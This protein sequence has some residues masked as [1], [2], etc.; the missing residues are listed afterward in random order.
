MAP[1]EIPKETGRNAI[2]KIGRLNTA[3]YLDLVIRIW[4][5]NRSESLRTNAIT[6]WLDEWC[7]ISDWGAL[8]AHGGFD[9]IVLH[10]DKG[11]SQCGFVRS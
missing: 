10:R 6:L 8:P 4:D 5:S 9:R 11:L 2:E 7:V 3:S 1:T